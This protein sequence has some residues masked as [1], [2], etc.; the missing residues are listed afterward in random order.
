MKL[1]LLKVK[2]WSNFD[3][4]QTF[5]SQSLI[6][7]FIKLWQN[8]D[9]WKSKFDQTLTKLRLLKVK[10]WSNFDKTQTFESQSL[11]KLWWKSI[12][13]LNLFHFSQMTV[14]FL[15]FQFDFQDIKSQTKKVVDMLSISFPAGWNYMVRKI[16]WR[17][18][19]ITVDNSKCKGLWLDQSS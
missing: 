9:F 3:K 2:V 11:I 13:I 17:A 14:S 16:Y 19:L 6:K 1:R 5:E 18:R 10:V 7:L 12:F 15:F 8:S 4:T